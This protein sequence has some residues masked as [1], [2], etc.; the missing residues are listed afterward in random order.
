MCQS[1][2]FLKIQPSAETDF[3]YTSLMLKIQLPHWLI[4]HL[5]YNYGMYNNFNINVAGHNKK[6]KIAKEIKHYT[7]NHCL[8]DSQMSLAPTMSQQWQVTMETNV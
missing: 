8:I 6:K 3:N 4:F 5:V 7:A 2:V 1:S